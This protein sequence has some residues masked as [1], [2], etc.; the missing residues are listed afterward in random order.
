MGLLVNWSKSLLFPID[1]AAHTTASLDLHLQ[2]V[3]RFRYLGVEISRQATD[4]MVL[5]LTHDT[6]GGL[7]KAKGMG[8]PTD[9]SFRA[10]FSDI[11]Q[12]Y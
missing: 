4:Y 12:S 2:W 5:N 8:V 10:H 1:P 3:E 9:I 6:P 11:L 7:A